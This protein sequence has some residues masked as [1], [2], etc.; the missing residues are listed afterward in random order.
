MN[1]STEFDPVPAIISRLVMEIRRLSN[2]SE[3]LTPD[4]KP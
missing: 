4:T 2:D 1:A 3:N